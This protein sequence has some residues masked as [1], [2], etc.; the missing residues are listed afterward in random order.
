MANN[1]PFQPMGKTVKVVVNGASNTQSNVF[2]ITADSPCQ[3]YLL[4]NA[5]VNSAVYVRINTSN[6][7]NVSLPDVTPDYVI[8]LPPYAAFIG[9]GASE[10][11]FTPGEG[12]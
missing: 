6:A 3:Q 10:A 7:F 9:E 12:T 11:Y 5:D 1:I 8:A 2:T 4:T